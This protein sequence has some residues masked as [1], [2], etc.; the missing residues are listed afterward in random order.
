MNKAE[1]EEIDDLATTLAYERIKFSG[2]WNALENHQID[3]KANEIAAK[4]KA[5]LETLIEK[6]ELAIEQKAA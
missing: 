5:H 6:E 2:L 4:V 1:Q 3:A